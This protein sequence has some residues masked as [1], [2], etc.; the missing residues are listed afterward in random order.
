MEKT[1]DDIN[2]QKKVW[3][4]DATLLT[5][6]VA[7]VFS[8]TSTIYS[9]SLDIK[10]QDSVELKSFQDN[11][12]RLLSVKMDHLKSLAHETTSKE[13]SKVIEQE[14]SDLISLLL[15]RIIP[16]LNNPHAKVTRI[17]MEEIASA[18]K[19]SSKGYHHHYEFRSSHAYKYFFNN[20]VGLEKFDVYMWDFE[21]LLQGELD[22]E[23]VEASLGYIYDKLFAKPLTVTEMLVFAK[24]STSLIDSYGTIV[25]YEA[26]EAMK[27][28]EMIEELVTSEN[29]EWSEKHKKEKA[30]ELNGLLKIYRVMKNQYSELCSR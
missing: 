16:Y 26:S 20:S 25:C 23:I 22:G 2:D 19:S 12:E 14:T 29:N 15:N 27:N 30:K 1:A 8:I 10:I 13:K 24:V 5:S 17:E 28:A 4:K 18:I 7:L 9:I 11:L 6:L 3:Y 21:Y